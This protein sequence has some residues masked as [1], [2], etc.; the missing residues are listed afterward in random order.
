MRFKNG[1]RALSP[2]RAQSCYREEAIARGDLVLVEDSRQLYWEAAGIDFSA[3]DHRGSWDF[4]VHL[5]KKAR[6]DAAV[7]SG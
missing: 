2:S 5:A 1:A 3:K 4:M 7:T 6:Y